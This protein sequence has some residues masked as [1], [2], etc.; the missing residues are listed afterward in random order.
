MNMKLLAT[1]FI[2]ILATGCSSPEDKMRD[3]FLSGCV[4]SGADRA[5]CNCVFDKLM[6]DFDVDYLERMNRRGMPTSEFMEATMK[7]GLQCRDL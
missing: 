6:T 1:L 3:Q 4:E 7:A 2:V 5:F